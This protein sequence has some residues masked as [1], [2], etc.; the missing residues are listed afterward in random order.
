MLGSESDESE[1]EL[2]KGTSTGGNGAGSEATGVG[3]VWA[4]TRELGSVVSGLGGMDSKAT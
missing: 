3:G 2:Y 1:D 4:G